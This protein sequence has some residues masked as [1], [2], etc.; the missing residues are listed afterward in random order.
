M[1]YTRDTNLILSTI[2]TKRMSVKIVEYL[3]QITAIY[4]RNSKI[5]RNLSKLNNLP[6]TL[7]AQEVVD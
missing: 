6:A 7:V 4:T 3:H 2:P 1:S 5:C